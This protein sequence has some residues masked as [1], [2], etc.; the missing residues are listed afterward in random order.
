MSVD[1]LMCCVCVF[2]VHFGLFFGFEFSKFR[3]FV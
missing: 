2:Y 1:V 3:R